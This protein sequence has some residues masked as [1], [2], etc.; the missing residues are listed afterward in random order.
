MWERSRAWLEDAG[1]ADLPDLDALQ[2]DA[3]APGYSY[4]VGQRLVL[5]SKE[6][7]AAR[8]ARSPDLWDAVALTFAEPVAEPRTAPERS[9]MAAGGWMG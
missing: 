7:M 6:R 4:D 9:R 2:A 5:E 8:G 3:C 1:G